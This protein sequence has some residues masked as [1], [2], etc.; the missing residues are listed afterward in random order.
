M[1]LAAEGLENKR[2][3]QRMGMTQ[4]K[5]AR[6]RKRFLEGGIAAPDRTHRSSHLRPRRSR[7]I[8][9]MKLN[10]G[11]GK[12]GIIMAEPTFESSQANMDLSVCCHL[13]PAELYAGHKRY[14]VA[15]APN[16]GQTFASSIHP[17]Q[18]HRL[19]PR[20][21]LSREKVRPL[22]QDTFSQRQTRD[23]AL[24]SRSILVD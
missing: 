24:A 13:F 4:E 18:T 14:S 22:Y 15:M 17:V 19:R 20:A 3:A 8:G 1:L 5:A 12:R 11:F 2:I 21:G 6:W 7:C 16:R 9:G 23:S 10:T